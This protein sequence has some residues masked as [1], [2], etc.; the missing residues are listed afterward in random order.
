MF[1]LS[2]LLILGLSGCKDS[3]Q[4][5]YPKEIRIHKEVTVT[6]ELE[7][8]SL[9]EPVII[10]DE[11]TIHWFMEHLND[12]V[13]QKCDK[14]YE[15]DHYQYVI[16]IGETRERLSIIDQQHFTLQL[17]KDATPYELYEGSF[18]FIEDLEFIKIED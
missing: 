14:P 2:L 15:G 7:P 9:Y 3:S 1:L 17:Q 5:S 16:E 6:D 18:N 4:K 8:K 11:T 13:Y 12:N 10:N